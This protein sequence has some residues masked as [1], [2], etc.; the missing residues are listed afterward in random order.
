MH[1][2]SVINFIDSGIE[3]QSHFPH[4]M[5]DKFDT[6]L[7]VWESLQEKSMFEGLSFD[8]FVANF[9]HRESD[10]N[11]ISFPRTLPCLCRN[12]CVSCLCRT[13]LKS[14]F[15]HFGTIILGSS[16]EFQYLEENFYHLFETWYSLKNVIH[17]VDFVDFVD[18]A[19]S[20]CGDVLNPGSR[21]KKR[22]QRRKAL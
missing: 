10:S 14:V 8:L 21:L 5:G 7:S 16:H 18:R 15:Y 9:L 19:T 2:N 11:T 3:S 1:K 6:L 13:C 17:L 4:K 12:S 20:W 22:K